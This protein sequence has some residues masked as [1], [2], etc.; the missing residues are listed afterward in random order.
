MNIDK[1]GDKLR[2][3]SQSAR[4]GR[5]ENEVGANVSDEII[6]FTPSIMDCSC[7]EWVDCLCARIGKEYITL[8]NDQGENKTWLLSLRE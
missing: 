3:E 8:N 6:R 1:T 5:R 7:L 2:D 4:S